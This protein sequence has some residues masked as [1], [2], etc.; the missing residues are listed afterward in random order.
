MLFVGVDGRCSRIAS[1]SLRFGL[2]TFH[3]PCRFERS[4]FNYQRVDGNFM[5]IFC[6][7]EKLFSLFASC[8][9]LLLFRLLNFSAIKLFI[10]LCL[11]RFLSLSNIFITNI[12][13]GRINRLEI[14]EELRLRKKEEKN[15]DGIIRIYVGTLKERSLSIPVCIVR[16]IVRRETFIGLSP[17]CDIVRSYLPFTSFRK[18]EM[19]TK[20]PIGVHLLQFLRGPT[21]RCNWAPLFRYNH[22][23]ASWA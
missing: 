23:E 18:W 5:E 12:F 10:I 4:L 14:T 13:I 9:V 11:F 19:N 1:I 21:P 16:T 6:A 17:I 3:Y 8:M 2:V 22:S 15:Y 7:A 20:R